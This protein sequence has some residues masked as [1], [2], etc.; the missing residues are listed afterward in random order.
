[1][2]NIRKL[3]KN[4]QPKSRNM[5]LANVGG[6]YNVLVACGANKGRSTTA[7]TYMQKIAN[8]TGASKW[9]NVDSGGIKDQVFY[10]G[11]R[12][13]GEIG[14]PEEISTILNQYGITEIDDFVAKPIS[15]VMLTQ[16][17]LVL[18]AD[19]S[20]RDELIRRLP[21]GENPNKIQTMKGYITGLEGAAQDSQLGTSDAQKFEGR[22]RED[23]THFKEDGSVD[24]VA[25]WR[26][27][28][29]TPET[30]E[31]ILNA[32]NG[33]SVENMGLGKLVID[34]IYGDLS[35]TGKIQYL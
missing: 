8:E 4:L 35:K 2:K 5:A 11:M 16:A 24:M 32:F 3:E 27:N 1:M 10:D 18:T 7:H 12:Q 20:V 23:A 17:D 13:R 31:G 30:R 19:V 9:L 21:F 22:F 28:R 6:K 14:A 15:R 33:M 29:H 26:D 34:K 25:I